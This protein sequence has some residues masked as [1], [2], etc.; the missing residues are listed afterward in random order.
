VVREEEGA[1]KRLVAYIVLD[2]G[3]VDSHIE[4]EAG[5]HTGDRA[6]EHAREH[7]REHRGKQTGEVAGE[8]TGERI[9]ER[10]REQLPGY[11]VPQWVVVLDELPLTPNGKVDRAALPAP[12]RKARDEDALPVRMSE[13]EE[14]VAQVW[15]AV[16]G[17]ER[18][19]REESFFELGGHSLLATQAVFRLREAF[20]I[21]LPLRTLL[22]APTVHA[23]S[24]AIDTLV[25]GG[26]HHQWASMPTLQRVN[27][28]GAL[29]LSFAQQRL[30]FVDQLEPGSAAYNLPLGVRLTGRLD[31]DALER[32]LHKVVQRHE[33]LRTR[34]EVSDA[35]PVQVV[36]SAFKIKLK[37]ID[38]GEAGTP[39]EREQELARQVRREAA[40][41][42]DLRAGSLLRATLW[43]VSEQEHVLGVVMHHIISDGWSMGVLVQELGECYE[44][45]RR[46][47]EPE[48]SQL[49]VQYADYALWQREWLEGGETERQMQYWREQLEGMAT[50]EMPTDHPR[51]R[52]QRYRGGRVRMMYG[53][54]LREKLEELSRR[55]GVTLF[56][57]L[58]AAFKTLLYRH[59]S[60]TDITIGS[61][62]A[63]R[64]R[65]E[66]ANL[67][68]FFVNM[69][70]LRTDL[71]GN[72]TFRELL[73]RVRRM[74]LD[75]YAHQELPFEK[76]VSELQPERSV[77]YSPIFSVV[78]VMNNTSTP[79]I[80]LPELTLTSFDIN[81]ETTHFDLTLTILEAADGLTVIMDYDADLFEASTIR[82]LMEYYENLLTGIA[83]D[84]DRRLLDLP[85]LRTYEETPSSPG[86]HLHQTYEEDHFTFNLD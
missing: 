55:E 79:S 8:Q 70:P 71:S 58:L 44:A 49:Q 57:T 66:T 25:R 38:L 40:Q 80:N 22:E 45:Y 30:W 43:R 18:V 62:V 84:A 64:S 26:E 67:I 10:L 31:V 61:P 50:L 46:G 9:R 4:E 2:A 74:A 14:M 75:A 42:F 15:A 32:S 20:D 34:F 39:A 48:L 35:K 23:L 36:R 6:E 63:G 65:G 47:H 52:V 19:G 54:E 29:P 78:F 76:L 69:L 1:G 16:L 56:M 59:L 73:K 11:L 33:T 28:E 51:P 83:T 81:P 53:A 77:S 85:L 37:V 21:E 86:T 41:A 68:G 72:P 5:E 17:V 60:Q 24:A 27:R 82:H 7:A 13:T 12:Q 3:K